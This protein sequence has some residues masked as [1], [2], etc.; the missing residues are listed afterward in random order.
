MEFL[1]GE[2]QSRVAKADKQSPTD[3]VA[4]KNCVRIKETL[5]K[6]VTVICCVW[7]LF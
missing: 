3:A 7:L 6:D 4:S 5:V 2:I 1:H